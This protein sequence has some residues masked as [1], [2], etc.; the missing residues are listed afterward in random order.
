MAMNWRVFKTRTLTAVVFAVVMLAGLLWNRWAFFALFSLVH[1]GCWYE[2]VQLLNAILKPPRKIPI[3]VTAGLA[4]AGWALLWWA[5]HISLPLTG[6]FIGA[7]VLAVA[8]LVLSVWQSGS[9]RT[10]LPLLGGLLYISVPLAAL[11]DLRN[12]AF[13]NTGG[14]VAD[15][16]RFL[17][18]L[19]IFS[20]WVNDTMAYITGSF[21]GKTPFSKISPKKT[22]EGTIGGI[23]LCVVAMHFLGK[24]LFDH[25]AF[26][27]GK[28]YL[29]ALVAA[30]TGTV[31]DLFESWLKR[32]AGVK[33]SGS[34]MPGHG[35]FLDRFDSLLFGALFV[36][37]LVKTLPFPLQCP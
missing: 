23:I 10:V 6:I 29:L 25:A 16:G 17:P 36:W 1:F 12:S 32:R 22:W 13:C 2:Y 37:L 24:I 9:T 8:G 19:I 35:G 3:W 21:I 26:D 28:V 20:M 11:T 15:F 7:G 30:V 4:I 18:C 33:D 14:T 31:G 34:F 27:T 5:L